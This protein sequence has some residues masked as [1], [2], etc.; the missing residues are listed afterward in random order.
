[1]LQH[2]LVLQETQGHI[3][4]CHCQ[5]ILLL[6]AVHHASKTMGLPIGVAH[7]NVQRFDEFRVARGARVE[8][9]HGHVLE[10]RRRLPVQVPLVTHDESWIANSSC[11]PSGRCGLWPAAGVLT[12]LQVL[13]SK[14]VELNAMVG[15][16]HIGYCGMDVQ[17]PVP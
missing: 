6:A 11:K 2:I 4:R 14:G 1:M 10:M 12:M 17:R 16:E 7:V 13:D 15:E 9:E 8:F 5:I 3:E